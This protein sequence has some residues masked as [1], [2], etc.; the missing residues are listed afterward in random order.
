MIN[1][2]T[3]DDETDKYKLRAV[4][5]KFEKHIELKVNSFLARYHFHKCYQM[6]TESIDEYITRCRLPASRC[7]F[8]DVMETNI[9]LTEQLIVGTRHREVQEKLLEKGDAL[10][11]LDMALDIARTY[12]ATQAHLA[13][14]PEA[15]KSTSTPT[16]VSEVRSKHR[17]PQQS[18]CERCGGNHGEKCPAHGD[19]CRQCGKKNHTG[20]K[21]VTGKR[22]QT[23]ARAE[24]VTAA[25]PA[26]LDHLDRSQAPNGM[27]TTSLLT[28]M[29]S[30]WRLFQ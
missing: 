21:C 6:P 17:S 5:E 16:S 1:S 19:F 10:D 2:W 24:Q 28:R 25:I 27:C 26:R 23:P 18:K 15:S 14:M 8:T 4:W 3:W 30:C 7:K 22:S 13:Q 11:S 9:R 20:Q 12:E 29:P